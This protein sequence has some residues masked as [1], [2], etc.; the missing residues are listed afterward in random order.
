M[1][2]Q[3]SAPHGGFSDANSTW[4]PISDKHLPKAALDQVAKSDSIYGQLSQFLKWRKSQPAMMHANFMSEVS[5]GDKQIIFDRVSD[6]QRLRCCFDLETLT[7]S[8]EEI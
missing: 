4:L 7:A 8:F 6:Q 5:G 2:W 3:A 1:V